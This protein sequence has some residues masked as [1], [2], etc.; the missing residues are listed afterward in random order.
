VIKFDERRCMDLIGIFQSVVTF[1][2]S[3]P[4]DEVLQ[5]LA[6]P[7]SPVTMDLFDFIFFFP[8]NQ[9]RGWSSEIWA[10]SWCFRK[11]G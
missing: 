5:G 6:M 3:L 11:Q 8:I 9:I 7:P 2:V 4:F 1:R 10:M